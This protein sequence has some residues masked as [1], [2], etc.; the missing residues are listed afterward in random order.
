MNGISEATRAAI[1]AAR[2]PT[3]V[4]IGKW[5]GGAAYGAASA[6]FA[7]C[8]D[9]PERAADAAE[10]LLADSGWV[11]AMLASLREALAQDPFFEPPFKVHRDALRTGAVLFDCP[12]A[13]IA[14]S[15]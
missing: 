12:A 4:A 15:V 9:A 2:T 10:R 6:A 3:A 8:A 7:D 11:E 14:A 5:R 13:S 1:V